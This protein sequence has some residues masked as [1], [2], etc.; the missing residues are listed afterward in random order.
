MKTEIVPDC[1]VSK[2]PEL[3]KRYLLG[4]FNE[5]GSVGVMIEVEADV[6]LLGSRGA[7]WSMM[8][9]LEPRRICVLGTKR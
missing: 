7:V 6:R 1:S 3:D 9:L 4:R 2:S 8:Y 5:S